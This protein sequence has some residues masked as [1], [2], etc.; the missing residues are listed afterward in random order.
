[1]IRLID[2][3]RLPRL[4]FSYYDPWLERAKRHGVTRVET[5]MPY[6][7]GSRWSWRLLAHAVGKN[8]AEPGS[9]EAE[10]VIVWYYSEMK[11]YFEDKGFH[12]FFC[13]ISDEIP[14]ER[15]PLHI[16]TAKLARRAGWRPFTTIT[17]MI[18][19]TAK[20]I[21]A[22]NP[23]CDQWQ[24]SFGLKDDFLNLCQKRFAVTEEI[25]DLNVVWRQYRNGGAQE[26]WASKILGP[27]GAVPIDAAHIETFQLLEDG[28]PL[29]QKGGSPWGNRDRGVVMT[30]GRLHSYLYISPTDGE[31]ED[32]Q[33][34]LKLSIRRESPN[35]APLVALDPTD[36]VWC[37]GGSSRP[38]R[39]PYHRTWRYPIM[40]LYH[41]F[42]G[43]G[44]WA[45]YHWNRTER[46]MWIDPETFRVT[47]SPPYCGY[48]DGWRDVLLFAQVREA[49][50]KAALA[51]IF[52]ES[53]DTALKIGVRSREVYSYKTVQNAPD[54]MAINLARRRALEILA[55]E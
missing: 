27:K 34:R 25:H 53:D 11:R 33:Y 7:S 47:V 8:R 44:L 16:E 48:R 43:Y 2:L 32:H 46:I 35:G 36:E 21:R 37:Y 14:P 50:G 51:S 3:N 49:K 22:M 10:R 15:I 31:P 4:D 5:Y 42:R 52:G 54:P 6:P 23:G 9:P 19:R 17:G 45:F 41:G 30:A 26:T 12:G 55:A 20:H 13:K 1:M 29:R 38:F 40:T 24:L 18:A 39:Q 28:K